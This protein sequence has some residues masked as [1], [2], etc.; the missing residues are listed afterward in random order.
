MIEQIEKYLLKKWD[1][2]PLEVAKPREFSFLVQSRHRIVV[3]LFPKGA[4]YPLIVAKI[5]RNETDS[6]FS[7]RDFDNRAKIHQ[8]ISDSLKKTIALPIEL[9]R[10]ANHW[11]LLETFL[12]GNAMYISTGRLTMKRNCVNNFKMLFE[13]L[14]KFQSQTKGIPVIF[15]ETK[16][17]QL[18]IEPII[19]CHGAELFPKGFSGYIADL[20]GKMKGK[21]VPTVFSYGDLHHSH[22]LVA[23]NKVS[24]V[25]DWESSATSGLPFSDWFQFLCEYGREMTKKEGL[26][27]SILKGHYPSVEKM[28]LQDNLISNV[29]KTWTNKL[30]A[31]YEMEQALIPLWLTKFFVNFAIEKEHKKHI[32]QMVTSALM[33]HKG[34]FFCDY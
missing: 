5:S 29:A 2:L 16:V 6:V 30:F 13:W 12:P 18:L 3:F 33:S 19:K 9:A 10:I 11:V 31:A 24:G 1:S 32:I 28:F 23:K 4:K 17:D 20:A 25:V 26:N 22:I 7:K 15:D 8:I 27:S 14:L 34:V 21:K